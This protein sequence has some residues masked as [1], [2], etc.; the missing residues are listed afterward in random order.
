[1]IKRKRGIQ[2]FQNFE[3]FRNFQKSNPDDP[4]KSSEKRIKLYFLAEGGPTKN[5]KR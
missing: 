2:N 1:M 3:I 4:S 5:L